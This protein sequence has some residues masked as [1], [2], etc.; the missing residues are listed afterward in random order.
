MSV[1]W[2]S[3]ASSSAQWVWCMPSAAWA[4][5][6]DGLVDGVGLLVDAGHGIEDGEFELFGGE[7]FGGAGRGDHLCQ[8]RGR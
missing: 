7:P 6:G 5:A 3:M 2:A 1:S 4:G 8:D